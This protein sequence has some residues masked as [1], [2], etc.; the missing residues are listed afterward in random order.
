MFRL[1]SLVGICNMNVVTKKIRCKTLVGDHDV[2]Y[3]VCY[4]L[5]LKVSR[6]RINYVDLMG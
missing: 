1:I 2:L 5:F 3:N 4:P 6:L